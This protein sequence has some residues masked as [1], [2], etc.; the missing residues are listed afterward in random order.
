M[1]F[2]QAI[3]TNIFSQ[4]R[5]FRRLILANLDHKNVF[6]VHFL[7]VRGPLRLV[8]IFSTGIDPLKS[9]ATVRRKFISFHQNDDI[10]HFRS[11]QSFARTKY[12]I[13]GN[14]FLR[15]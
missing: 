13:H 5:K 7:N 15:I 1:F 10:V 12:A 4:S 3:P 9:L 11:F 14:D 8:V 2:N 6:L